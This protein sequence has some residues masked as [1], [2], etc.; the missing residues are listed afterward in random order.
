[1]SMLLSLPSWVVHQRGIHREWGR[2]GPRA[3]PPGARQ[4]AGRSQLSAAG[5]RHCLHRSHSANNLA[6]CSSATEQACSLWA[7]SVRW[8][9]LISDSLHSFN[10]FLYYLLVL[11]WKLR[12]IASWNS[13]LSTICSYVKSLL[14]DQVSCME[15]FFS[16]VNLF[17]NVF[18]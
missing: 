18:L 12:S 17:T 16:L 7:C 13:S 2:A 3:V 9:R 8:R 4:T 1:M 6:G 15:H 11:S 10:V 14:H 5:V